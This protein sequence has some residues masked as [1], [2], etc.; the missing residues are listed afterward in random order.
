MLIVRYT[1]GL[2]NQMFQYALMVILKEHFSEEKIYADLTRYDLTLEHDGFDL[3]K[4]FNIKIDVVSN[5]TLKKIAPVNYWCKRLH[6]KWILH[7]LSVHRTEKINEKLEKGYGEIGIIPDYSATN[8]N[9]DAFS[10]NREKNNIWHYKG[11]WI[12]PQ[13]WKG[14]EQQVARSFLFK[15]ELLSDEDISL[16]HRMEEEESIAV[17]IRKGDYT[18]KYLYDICN[19]KYYINAIQHIIEIRKNKNIRVYIFSETDNLKLNF[20][21]ELDYVVISHPKQPGIDMW[22]MSKCKHNIIANSTFSFWSAFLNR[23]PEKIVIAPMYIYRREV[24][25]KFVVPDK[26]ILINNLD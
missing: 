1:G 23:N 5:L 12:N 14:Y 20:C 8:F 18:G 26:W 10:L 22:L 11:N 19:E 4:Y 16:I 17:H 25:V 15:E 6:V 3:I 9:K 21:K 2:G 7:L 13:Y 24:Y